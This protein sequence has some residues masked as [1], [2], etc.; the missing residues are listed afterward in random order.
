MYTGE[1]CTNCGRVRVEL[2]NGRRICEKCNWNQDTNEYDNYFEELIEK[3]LE[4]RQ[5][6]WSSI[7]D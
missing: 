3:E 6:E 2:I 5:G 7:L 1:R 4:D